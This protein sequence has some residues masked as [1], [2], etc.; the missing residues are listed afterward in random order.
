L[1]SSETGEQPEPRGILSSETPLVGSFFQAKD[2]SG[3]VNKAYK[4]MEEVVQSKET[5]KK[6]MEEGRESE[7]E[8][9]MDA[10]ADMIAMGTMAG[11]FRKKMG[12][13]TKQER[14]VRADGGLSGAEKRE[15][16][17]EIKQMK[18]DLAKMF[19]S[20]RE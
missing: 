20:A 10:N 4:D 2:A 3:L 5:Y 13:L 11:K 7:A 8:A 12:D 19:S 9:Y 16:L 18:I 14:M 17:D 15:A 6:M 1:R